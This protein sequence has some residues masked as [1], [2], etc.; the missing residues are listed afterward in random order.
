[1]KP[2]T[3]DETRGAAGFGEA[4]QRDELHAKHTASSENPRKFRIGMFPVDMHVL[5]DRLTP[6]EFHAYHRFR[7]EYIYAGADGLVD[8][9][10]DLVRRLK[11]KTWSAVKAK[12]HAVGALHT[13][14][15]VL[16]DRDLDIS[17]AAQRKTSK[18][19]S[20]IARTRW[21]VAKIGGAV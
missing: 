14:A 1:M 19:Q 12:L 3:K 7:V 18:R 15:G 11:C 6:A 16:R 21:N 20:A 13:D 17:I 10:A 9:D 8:D 2:P 4:A 5:L